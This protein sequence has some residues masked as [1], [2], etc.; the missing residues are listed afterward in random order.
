[1]QPPKSAQFVALI[2]R[3]DPEAGAV[4]R[5]VGGGGGGGWTTNYPRQTDVVVTPAL[6]T[7]WLCTC[8]SGT[9][10]TAGGSWSAASCGCGAEGRVI[11]ILPRYVDVRCSSAYAFHSV[12]FVR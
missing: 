11:C 2:M 8:C 9:G 5:A 1:M 12:P 4:L 3:I 10:V 7:S 6:E